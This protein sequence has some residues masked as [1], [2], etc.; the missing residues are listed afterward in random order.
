MKDIL[1]VEMFVYQPHP[2]GSL[3]YL[4]FLYYEETNDT[5]WLSLGVITRQQILFFPHQEAL[6]LYK[7]IHQYR[8]FLVVYIYFI[9]CQDPHY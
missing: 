2:P 1:V 5:L 6:Y 7:P 3:L 8:A 4:H 9:T